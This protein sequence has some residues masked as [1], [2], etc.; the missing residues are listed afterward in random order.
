M[1]KYEQLEKETQQEK[2][3]TRIQL[4][5]ILFLIL[6]VSGGVFFVRQRLRLLRKLRDAVQELTAS[7]VVIKQQ[8]EHLE[9]LNA[10]KIR[11]FRIVAHDLKAP[12]HSL[13]I[14]S[15]LSEV[16]LLEMPAEDLGKLLQN[17]NK[18][19]S[20][21][22]RMADNLMT[23]AAQQMNEI[24]FQPAKLQLAPIV[25]EILDVFNSIALQKNIAISVE[26]EPEVTVFADANQVSF[27]LRNLIN[28][29]IKFTNSSGSVRIAAKKSDASGFIHISVSDT[30]IG[31]P[32]SKMKNLFLLGENRSTTGTN[33][34]KGTGLGLMLV[35][36]FVKRNGGTIEVSSTSG[37][38]SVFTV[39]LPSTTTI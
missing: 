19:V 10:E 6:I 30:G 31:I 14:F 29:A 15:S 36:N 9:R 13:M 32:E 3:R 2:E 12:L 18:S 38:G 26:I 21:T 28:N 25:T 39:S 24:Q 1:R 16:D 17:L 22:I 20:N 11:F 23:W 8:N 37:K 33:G 34:E 7:Q 5:V 35:H 4:I 27:I